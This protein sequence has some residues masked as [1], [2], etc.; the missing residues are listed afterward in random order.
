MWICL[1]ISASV[2][3]VTD[4]TEEEPDDDLRPV[5][6]YWTI[7]SYCD[8]ARDLNVGDDGN[9]EWLWWGL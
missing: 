4:Q 9:D 6:G 7:L 5:N 3:P 8:D 2:T 1:H